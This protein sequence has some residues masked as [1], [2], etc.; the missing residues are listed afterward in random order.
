MTTRKEPVTAEELLRMPDDG[1]RYELVEGELRKMPPAGNEHGY[2]ALELAAELRNHVKAN[3]LGRTYTPE[4]GFRISSAPD[5]VR[6]PDA[7]FVSCE[8]LAEVGRK[9]GFW[10]GAPDLAAEVVSPNDTHA[11]VIEK[12]LTWLEA[13]CRMVVVADPGPRTVTVYRSAA[14]IRVLTG[15]DVLEG[16]DVVPGW[17]PPVNNLFE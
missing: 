5:T 3:R 2:V 14:D 15:D 12:A 10:P 11:E 1:F 9:E 16:A 8:R 6:A 7:A 13:G 17:R 4:T